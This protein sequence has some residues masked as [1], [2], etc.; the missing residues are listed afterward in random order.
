MKD[1]FPHGPKSGLGAYR[2][3][4]LHIF[5]P[6]SLLYCAPLLIVREE[7]NLCMLSINNKVSIRL[8]FKNSELCFCD[9]L[10]SLEHSHFYTDSLNRN[11]QSMENQGRKR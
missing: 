1:V 10:S 8:F 7:K 9:L 4:D 6:L 2:T 11:V 5:P 3:K